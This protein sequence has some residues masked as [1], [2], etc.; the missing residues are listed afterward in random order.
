MVAAVGPEGRSDNLVIGLQHGNIG[1]QHK[2]KKYAKNAPNETNS[3][4]K[5]NVKN[6][7][8]KN[9]TSNI[10]AKIVSVFHERNFKACSLTTT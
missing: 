5:R 3:E 6:L 10:I 8:V 7:Q 1:T 9:K 2:F 4:K